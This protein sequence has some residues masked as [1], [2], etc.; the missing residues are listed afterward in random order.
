M[1]KVKL[2]YQDKPLCGARKEWGLKQK[3]LA[4]RNG[5]EIVPIPLGAEKGLAMKAI[6]AGIKKLPFFTDGDKYAYGI[7]AFIETPEIEVEEKPKRKTRRKG[8]RNGTSEKTD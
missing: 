2:V 4:G 5:I 8:S 6:E 3:D 1:K 7:D